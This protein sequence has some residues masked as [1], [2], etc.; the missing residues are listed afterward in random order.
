MDSEKKVCSISKKHTT[1][2]FA[3]KCELIGMDELEK[4]IQ[5]GKYIILPCG[6]SMNLFRFPLPKKVKIHKLK[7]ILYDEDRAENTESKKVAPEQEG[8]TEPCKTINMLLDRLIDID[9]CTAPCKHCTHYGEISIALQEFFYSRIAEAVEKE[10]ERIMHGMV[11]L[12]KAGKDIPICI[13]E[14]V[15]S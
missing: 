8:V 7:D 1:C 2:E 4:N 10:K 14:L 15:K 9:H 12:K 6:Y 5:S 13:I 11:N 3:G